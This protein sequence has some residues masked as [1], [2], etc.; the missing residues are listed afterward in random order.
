MR[1]I[2]QLSTVN[3]TY[4]KWSKKLSYNNRGKSSKKGIKKPDKV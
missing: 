1:V 2:Q 4:G 3:K